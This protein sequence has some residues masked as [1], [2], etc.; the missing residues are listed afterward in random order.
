MLEKIKRKAGIRYQAEPFRRIVIRTG[1]GIIAV[2]ILLC[3]VEIKKEAIAADCYEKI[4]YRA[5]AQ[6]FP[7]QE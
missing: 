4:L 7:L 3:Y 2:L 6:Q 1:S 5:T